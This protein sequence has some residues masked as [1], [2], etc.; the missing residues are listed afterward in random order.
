MQFLEPEVEGEAGD[1]A[2]DYGD[3]HVSC[4]FYCSFQGVESWKVRLS[5]LELALG[6][7]RM[8]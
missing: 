4:D 2:A 5:D 8:Y 3:L 1:A 6:P 7:D